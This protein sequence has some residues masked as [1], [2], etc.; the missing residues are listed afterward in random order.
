[1]LAAP[2]AAIAYIAIAAIA[3]SG[4]R[5]FLPFAAPVFFVAP[6]AFIL[7][8][9]VRYRFARA[10]L[11]RLAPAPVAIRMLARSGADRSAESASI[12]ATVLFCDLIGSSG[13]GEK[14]QP[15]AFTALLNEFLEL[16]KDSVEMHGGVVLQFQGDG[17]IAAYT[18][19]DAGS[20]HAV[21]ACRSTVGAVRELRKMNESNRSRGLPELHMRIG[22]NSGS[23]A[24]GDVGARDR[25]N[26]TL[27][28]DAV[29]LASR[30]EQMGKTLFPGET[31]VAL[32]GQAT[33]ALAKDRDVVFVDCG[34]QEIRGRAAP[35]HVYRI[36]TD[37]LP[38][39]GSVLG[40]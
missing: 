32:V 1:M 17:L 35:E 21:K 4:Y 23:V 5:L 10:L 39:T 40:R 34:L 16:V 8:V 36:L 18:R 7:G 33:F 15:V 6:T 11:M 26:F 37:D 25:Y 24:E 12:D 13:V 3:F 19:T 29:N 30:F 14:L 2:V 9:F 31:E 20:D 27:I 28:G 22:I 38:N